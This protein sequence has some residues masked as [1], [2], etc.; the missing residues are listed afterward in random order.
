[1]VTKATRSRECDK[2][3]GSRATS[4]NKPTDYFS[5]RGRINLVLLGYLANSSRAKVGLVQVINSMQA[6]MGFYG[7]RLHVVARASFFD[8]LRGQ[9]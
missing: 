3:V 5:M 7:R 8:S 6:K 2:V 9:F 1:M 4:Q